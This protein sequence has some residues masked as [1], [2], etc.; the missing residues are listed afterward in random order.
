MNLSDF[1]SVISQ[2]VVDHKWEIIASDKESEYFTII[3]EELL[4][5]EHLASSEGFLEELLHLV[6]LLCWDH[7][8]GLSKGVNWH[9]LCIWLWL[10]NTLERYRLYFLKHGDLKTDIEELSGVLISII[11]ADSSAEDA[12]I[13]T[14]AEIS[15]QERSAR[16]ILFE[17]H[18][19]FQ[20]DALRSAGVDFLWF[21]DHE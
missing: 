11:N 16:A 12:N 3:I 1:A 13:K 21:V 15:W 2:V 6:V 20:E 8:L 18:L 19:S 14:D 5:R 4:L 7:F 9:L 17:D 10:S